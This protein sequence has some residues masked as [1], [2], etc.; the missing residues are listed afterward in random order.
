MA[1]VAVEVDADGQPMMGRQG[2]EAQVVWE[3]RGQARGEEGQVDV[4]AG[5]R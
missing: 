1:G 4:G 2:Q 5:Q 3:A